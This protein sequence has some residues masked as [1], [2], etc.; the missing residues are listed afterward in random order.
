M[1][2]L[3]THH[4]EEQPCSLT[5]LYGQH[6]IFIWVTSHIH[7]GNN[8]TQIL[9]LQSKPPNYHLCCYGHHFYIACNSDVKFYFPNAT[10]LC[11][12][13]V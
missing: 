1:L 3:K 13:I 2:L 8:S 7:L 10:D 5:Q 4:T 6:P 11:R 9:T 12:D